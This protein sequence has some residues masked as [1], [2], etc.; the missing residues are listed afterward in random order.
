MG[1]C[2]CI[3]VIKSDTFLVG[4]GLGIGENVRFADLR[5]ALLLFADDVVSLLRP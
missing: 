3:L 2:V 5:I 1:V 4:I